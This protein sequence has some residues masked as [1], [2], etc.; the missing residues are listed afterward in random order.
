MCKHVGSRAFIRKQM[1]RYDQLNALKVTNPDL[2][3]LIAVGGW[4]FGMAQ[5]TLML[6]SESNRTKFID[7]S[8]AFC[9]AHNFDGLDLDFE[10]PANRGSPPVD[11]QNF[12]LLVQV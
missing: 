12:A 3:T 4:T 9:R 1:H 2:K 7:H 11:K 6:S 8:I 5:A 10:Y